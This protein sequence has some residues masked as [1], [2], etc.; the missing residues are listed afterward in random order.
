MVSKSLSFPTD[1]FLM[2]N[3]PQIR[4]EPVLVVNEFLAV[5]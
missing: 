3:V 2:Q 5:F 4:L 1:V